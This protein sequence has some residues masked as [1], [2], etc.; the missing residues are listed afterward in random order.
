MLSAMVSLL[1]ILTF[2]ALLGQTFCLSVHQARKKMQACLGDDVCLPFEKEALR[3]PDL[4][5]YL[6]NS[7]Q[8]QSAVHPACEVEI[9]RDSRLILLPIV[10]SYHGS[11]SLEAVLMSSESKTL[12]TLCSYGG[13]QCEGGFIMK[14]H[15]YRM[16]HQEDWSFSKM[17]KLYSKVWN[18][19]KPILLDKTPLTLWYS[20]K[21][22][23]RAIHKGPIP[24]ALAHRGVNNVRLAYVL[25]WR[26]FCLGQLSSHWNRTIIH[27]STRVK[28]LVES[29]KYLLQRGD[30]VLV[31]NYGDLLW[32]PSYTK[33]RLQHFLPCL[34]DL[35]FNYVPKLGEDIFPENQWKQDGSVLEFGATIDP[36]ECCGYDVET[37]RCVSS[38]SS[39]SGDAD[40]KECE[41]YLASYS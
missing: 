31:V 5:S 27:E 28:M 17:L 1:V 41:K 33:G 18:L 2:S 22:E 15:G 7:V 35:D 30:P 37:K 23:N 8:S 21:K 16:N 11:T 29:H 3:K 19:S 14:D 10:P 25:M 38:N 24:S 32:S 6:D 4:H 20:A 36:E 40:I 34:G 9:P 39:E 26:P 13:Y 12:S